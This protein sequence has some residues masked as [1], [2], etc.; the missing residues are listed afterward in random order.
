MAE[1]LN[2]NADRP[3][4][5]LVTDVNPIDQLKTSYRYALNAIN[6]VQDGNRLLLSN[7]MS[8][9][10]CYSFQDGYY[11]IGKVYM[12][13]NEVA[14]FL[15][16]GVL[17]E[18]GVIK[19]CNYT[20][21]F[22]SA[23]LNFN[24]EYQIDATYRVK[25]GCERIIY[26]TD[27]YNPVRQINLDKLSDY[28]SQAYIDWLRYPFGPVPEQFDCD[29]FELIS[30]YEIPCFSNIEVI[31]GGTLL[32]GSY[33]FAIQLLDRDFN[34]TNWIN[35]SRPVVIYQSDP[36][37]SYY[38]IEGSSNLE[39]DALGGSSVPTNKAVQITLSN[40]DP[41]YYYYRIAA[42]EAVSFS[43]LIT[44]VVA[45]PPISVGQD[46]FIY[47]GDLNGYTEITSEEIKLGRL[48]LEYAA[49]LEQLENRLLIG[50]TKGKQVNFCEFQQYASKI[51]SK[52]VVK[53]V[54]DNNPLAEGNPKNPETL[55]KFMG[56]MGGEVYAFGIVYVFN[57]GFESPAYHIPGPPKNYR[58]DWNTDTCVDIVATYGATAD[59]E[60]IM[61]WNKDMQFIIPATEQASYNANP[62]PDS[63]VQQWQ[64]YETAIATNPGVE[65][66]MGFW[67]CSNSLYPELQSCSSGDYWGNDFCGNAI[68]GTKIRHHKFPTRTLETHV[69]NDGGIVLY[70]NMVVTIKLLTTFPAT[71][72]VYLDVDYDIGVVPQATFNIAVT[73]ADFAT[74]NTY[75]VN[76][77][78]NQPLD[79]QGDVSNVVF[80]NDMTTTYAADFEWSYSVNFA[81]QQ[82]YNN[83]TLNLLGIQFDNVEYPNSDIVGHYFVRAERDS[84]NRTILDAGIG[85]QMRERTASV[86]GDSFPYITFSYF[87]EYNGNLNTDTDGYHHYFFTPK[88]MY[89]QEQLNPDYIRLERIFDGDSRSQET[90]LEEDGI[91]NEDTV[92]TAKILNYNGTYTS[93]PINL[94][95]ERFMKLNGANYDDAFTTTVKLYNLSLINNI[96]VGRMSQFLPR[97][98]LTPYIFDI[99]TTIPGDKAPNAI[100][101][102]YVTLKVNRD[103]HCNLDSIKY[104]RIHDCLIEG[105]TV[106]DSVTQPE[107]F[108]GDVYISQFNLF[109]IL[110]YNFTEGLLTTFLTILAIAAA[111]VATVLTFGAAAPVLI[112]VIVL[113]TIGITATAVAGLVR[114]YKET[115]LD[116]LAINFRVLK[117]KPVTL[118]AYAWYVSELTQ[119][120]YVESEINPSLRQ[121]E[122]QECGYYYTTQN[123]YDFT[124]EKIMYFNTD[125]SEWKRRSAPCPE[126]YHYNLDYSRMNKEKVYF[127]L[128][129]SYDCCSEC[130]EK[131]P[132]R[133]YYS[134]QS[135]QEERADNYKT[136]LPNNYRDIEAEHGEITG[137]VRKNNSLFVFTRECLW[138]LPQSVQQSIVNEI[139][140][141]IG[142]GEYFNIPPRKIIDSDMGT[143]GTVHKWS[144][145][146]C[147]LGILFFSEIERAV[148]LIGGE[149]GLSKISN[150][151]LFNWFQQ[152]S[153]S[154]LNDQFQELELIDFPNSNNPANPNGIGIHSVYDPR[155]Q[156]VI[157]T[158]R[159]YLILSRYTALFSIY[160]GVIPMV[161]GRMIYDI[162]AHVFG[163]AT[164]PTTYN[165]ISLDDA[166]YFEN[167]SFTISYSVLTQT[168]ISFH[169]YIPLFYFSDQNNYFSAIDETV[170]KHNVE[171]FFQTYYGE[172]FSH[173]LETVSVSNPLVTRLWNDISLQTI[174]RKYDSTEK[175]YL[176]ERD[177]T[178]EFITLY[179]TRQISGE[180]QLIVKDLQSNPEDY[181]ENQTTNSNTSIVIDR[182]ERDWYI[183]DFRDM[184]DDYTQPMF[185]RQWF[186]IQSVFPIDKVV[187]TAVIDINKDWYYQESFRDKYLIIRLRFSNFDDIQLTTNFVIESEQN[188]YR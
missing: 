107:I 173:I 47:N 166:D 175:E 176:E 151:G 180:L 45:S 11:L 19:N 158:K 50:N 184:R 61:T 54:E 92:I 113:S 65:G 38:G 69:D 154:F 67:E 41:S 33:N 74:S 3:F 7:E 160:N 21:I 98:P 13:N 40:I 127:P 181:Y 57:D 37:A 179:N 35:V 142:S 108:G 139:V 182:K 44:K 146:K 43:G 131:F 156:R 25:N 29:K 147:P 186:D 133:I 8:N 140:T 64:I 34:P 36:N 163:I 96:Y 178:F 83:S 143:A 91:G 124:K 39:S 164:S 123:F 157:F 125:D 150:E 4:K 145:I 188:S 155:H 66:H 93:S 88:L 106:N 172:R 53:N 187:N 97:S 112:G 28:F 109:N 132:T 17:S 171:G 84:F 68:A 122:N 136:I 161:A 75:T 115:G 152:Y 77:F 129:I 159:D 63:K 73:A 120:L 185:T 137:L 89:L 62:N 24:I 49:H 82:Q 149:Q 121:R 162:N 119:G 18:I 52:Y 72:T 10:E 80:S 105:D 90:N 14:V 110:F 26:F 79:G 22:S 71:P 42:I 23:C 31:S 117:D 58:W 9:E 118:D 130:L 177:I 46:V 169:S 87:T 114:Y 78:T 134:E 103:V 60:P 126:P 86:N 99:F 102:P 12:T 76:I 101:L 1:D 51:A 170:W 153:K 165:I 135:F 5:G 148:Y 59:D 183:N 15:T 95:I 20:S 55:N 168:W 144:I 30:P 48:D 27:N 167:K 16:N 128:P 138:N 2:K 70:Y 32:A 94:Y 85:H 56:F 174:A 100:D 116:Q 111:A 141:F 81:Y 104:Y 6:E